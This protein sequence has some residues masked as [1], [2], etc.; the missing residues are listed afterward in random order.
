M[1]A[2]SKKLQ[3]R[4]G[5]SDT[6]TSVRAFQDILKALELEAPDSK[7]RNDYEVL[8]SSVNPVRL[9]NNPIELSEDDLD[10]LYHQI[11]SDTQCRFRI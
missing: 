7:D 10:R 2:F 5:Y 9:K 6:N 11:F 1:Q 4:W 8:K 3:T